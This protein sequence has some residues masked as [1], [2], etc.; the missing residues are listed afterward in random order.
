MSMLLKAFELYMLK[1][2]FNIKLNS[3]SNKILSFWE[4]EFNSSL[5]KHINF[6]NKNI[7]NQ[8]NIIL[9]FQKYFKEMNI[10]ESEND[11]EK[12]ENQKNEQDNNPDNNDQNQSE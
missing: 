6:L 1:N 9:N 4:K 10:F 2:F 5:G 8:E 11:N 7:E 3:L 12:N